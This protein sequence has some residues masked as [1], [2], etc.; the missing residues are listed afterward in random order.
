MDMGTCM[1]H[2]PAQF[3]TGD[4]NMKSENLDSL[5]DKFQEKFVGLWRFRQYGHKAMFCVTYTVNGYYYDT[6]GH[7]TPIKALKAAIGISKRIG[8]R[9]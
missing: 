4:K 2:R 9:K 5:I 3:K 6:T 7:D 1:N 8:K